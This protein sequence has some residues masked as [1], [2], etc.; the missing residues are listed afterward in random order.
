MKNLIQNS[1]NKLLLM[2]TLLFLSIASFAQDLDID[3][4]L[5]KDDEWYK[6]PMYL[7]GIGVFII[8]LV[9]VSKNRKK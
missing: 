3:V 8:L 9:I 2:F 5:N 4:D 7:I 6:N 1:T